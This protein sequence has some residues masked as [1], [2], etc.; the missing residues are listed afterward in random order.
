MLIFGA[1]LWVH[2]MSGSSSMLAEAMHSVADVLNQ[3][4]W[5]TSADPRGW[6]YERRPESR[7]EG[8]ALTGGGGGG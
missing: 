7:G 3:V 5:G 6:G 2:T 4:G 1:K 8:V